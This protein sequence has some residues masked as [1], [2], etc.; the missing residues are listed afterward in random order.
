MRNPAVGIIQR[1][2]GSGRTVA[3]AESLTG[4]L[5]CA[6]LTAVPG[7]SVAVRGGIVAYGTDVKAHVLGVDEALLRHA[8]PVDARVAL[9]MAQGVRTLLTADYAVA[10]TG[11]A[12]PDSATGLPVGTVHIAVTGPQGAEVESVEL[13]GDREQ[14]RAGAT[15]AALRLLARLLEADA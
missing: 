5:V 9:A 2:S 14:V 12:G 8:G 4:G 10:T 15:D 1:L 11:E 7:A 6:A 3:A 13:P